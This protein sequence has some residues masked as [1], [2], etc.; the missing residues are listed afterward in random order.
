[1]DFISSDK[2]DRAKGTI[3]VSVNPVD[4]LPVKKSTERKQCYCEMDE[5]RFDGEGKAA[6]DC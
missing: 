1:M 2:K 5:I 4:Y 6:A 3:S